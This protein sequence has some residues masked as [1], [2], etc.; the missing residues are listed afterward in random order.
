MLPTNHTSCE[1]WAKQVPGVGSTERTTSNK[2]PR[3]LLV[4][5]DIPREI[6]KRFGEACWTQANAEHDGRSVLPKPGRVDVAQSSCPE[7]AQRL[8][9][10]GAGI[11]RISP[12][13]D[14]GTPN[15]RDRRE[16][17]L[18]TI[19]DCELGRSLSTILVVYMTPIL[20]LSFE[21]SRRITAYGRWGRK[22]RGNGRKGCLNVQ[23]QK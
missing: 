19:N 1:R 3:C 7:S 21:R 8:P 13:Q 17:G 16:R 6:E 11:P 23:E 22:P 14:P 18:P 5:P 2:M 20:V 9:E 4:G 10:G 15:R 12:G